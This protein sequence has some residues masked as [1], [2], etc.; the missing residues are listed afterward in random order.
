VIIS[1]NDPHARFYHCELCTYNS[2]MAYG[3]HEGCECLR[4]HPEK[5]TLT[6]GRVVLTGDRLNEII[7]EAL[8]E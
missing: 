8:G 5:H 3:C 2:C 4:D 6:Q 1:P 7:T